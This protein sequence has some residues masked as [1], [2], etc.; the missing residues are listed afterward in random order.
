MKLFLGL[1]GGGSKTAAVLLDEEANIVGNGVGGPGNIATQS[2][3]TLESSVR[4][5]YDAACL[6]AGVDANE[7]ELSGVCAGV[8]GYSVEPK[9]LQYEE[10]LKAVFPESHLQVEPD[11]LIAHWG[12]THGSHGI[13]V[14]AGTGAVTFG[15]NELGA[16]CRVDGL[17]FLLGDRGSGFN[18]GIRA[19]KHTLDTLDKGEMDPLAKVVLEVTNSTKQ[20]QI[21][22]WLYSDFQPAKVAALAPAIGAVAEIGD[23]DAR[24]LISLMAR[25]L[26]HSVRQVRH[27]LWMDRS[28]PIYTL[29]GLWNISHFFQSEFRDPQWRLIPPWGSGDDE[30][31]GG[32]FAVEEPLD[33]PAVGAAL[34]ARSMDTDV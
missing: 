20:S 18:L 17:G 1:D 23:P 32:R 34:L 13:V 2:E 10:L 12:A 3:Q 6:N 8:A 11:Y 24:S 14:I 4:T 19:L 7:I 16:S 29:G 30:M 15:K 22:H 25:Q 9:R 28:V 5:A 26:R 21:L 31:P 33:E 27:T